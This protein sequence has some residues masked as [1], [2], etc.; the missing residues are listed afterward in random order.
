MP[1]C[2]L[3]TDLY[4]EDYLTTC[5]QPQGEFSWKGELLISKFSTH[6]WNYSTLTCPKA[7]R[8][9]TTPTQLIKYAKN[10]IGVACSL[11]LKPSTDRIQFLSSEHMA[12]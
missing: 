1:V 4:K 8:L 6:I 7:N 5:H 3:F 12:F 9:Q 2:V 11:P 10:A